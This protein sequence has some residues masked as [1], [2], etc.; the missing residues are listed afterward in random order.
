[1][2]SFDTPCVTIHP[3]KSESESIPVEPIVSDPSIRLQL[4]YL[5][6]IFVWVKIVFARAL[7]D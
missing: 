6:C 2:Q 5:V 1:M 3:R 4:Y 7:Y